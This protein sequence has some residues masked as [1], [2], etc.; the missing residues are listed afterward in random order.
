MVCIVHYS[1]CSS[2]DPPVTC[3]IPPRVCG[4]FPMKSNDVIMIDRYTSHTSRDLKTSK[5]STLSMKYIWYSPQKS[6]YPLSLLS[7]FQTCCHSNEDT[8]LTVN[9]KTE[10]FIHS[11]VHSCFLSHPFVCSFYVHSMFKSKYLAS[12]P[13][14]VRLKLISQDHISHHGAYCQKT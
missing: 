4:G 9:S 1:D 10:T 3:I 6:K 8:N 12:L 7:C 13:K 11:F 2:E 14:P 5:F